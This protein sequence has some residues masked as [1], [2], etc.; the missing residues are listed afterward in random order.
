MYFERLFIMLMC[1]LTM[2][3]KSCFSDAELIRLF[4]FVHILFE[5]GNY[6]HWFTCFLFF[7]FLTAKKSDT[8]EV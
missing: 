1:M 5:M 6:L 2:I 3:L 7:F 4:E 8:Q